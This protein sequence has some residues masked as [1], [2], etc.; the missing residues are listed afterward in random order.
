M[1]GDGYSNLVVY[2]KS[3]A[4]V[5]FLFSQKQLNMLLEALLLF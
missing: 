5:K 1:S 2:L 3:V 4:A